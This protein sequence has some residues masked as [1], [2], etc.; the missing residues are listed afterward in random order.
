MYRARGQL[1]TYRWFIL[2][3]NEQLL[4]DVIQS[5]PKWEGEYSWQNSEVRPFLPVE[6]TFQYFVQA[7]RNGVLFG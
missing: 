1:A 6:A 4:H 5:Q 2:S 7:M 3:D